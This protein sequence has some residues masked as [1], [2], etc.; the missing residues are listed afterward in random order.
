MLKIH[1]WFDTGMPIYSMYFDRCGLGND[2]SL[3]N[4]S[5]NPDLFF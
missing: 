4:M 2:T 5:F 1:V 3:T